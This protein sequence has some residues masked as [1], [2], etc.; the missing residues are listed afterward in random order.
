M[1]TFTDKPEEYAAPKTS[2]DK[3]RIALK[4]VTIDEAKDSAK[5]F[6]SVRSRHEELANDMQAKDLLKH[7]GREKRGKA[8]QL[9]MDLLTDDVEEKKETLLEQV[10][11]LEV[12]N[13]IDPALVARVRELLKPRKETKARAMP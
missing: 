7:G 12:K 4:K 8:W 11:F 2:A 3:L 13:D 5:G 1:V 10:E 9:K 6:L